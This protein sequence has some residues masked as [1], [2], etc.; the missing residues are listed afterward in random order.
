MICVYWLVTGLSV[1]SFVYGLWDCASLHW[2]VWCGFCYV[3][4]AC[5]WSCLVLFCMLLIIGL[6]VFAWLILLLGWLFCL[7]WYNAGGLV[8]VIRFLLRWIV[9]GCCG[10]G[11]VV[12]VVMICL[13][14]VDCAARCLF[15][16]LLAR[17]GVLLFV[18]CRLLELVALWLTL[19][20][21]C[22]CYMFA[23]IMFGVGFVV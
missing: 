23:V 10:L 21:G 8:V 19:C 13:V 1:R 5:F 14:L 11:L 9:Y 22:C 7:G 17:V 2:V 4:W 18:S 15:C 16:W 20:V 6:L 3:C 12:Y